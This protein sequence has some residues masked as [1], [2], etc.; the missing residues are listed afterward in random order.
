MRPCQC[1]TGC[2]MFITSRNPKAKYNPL[3]SSLPA[4]KARRDA[5]RRQRR[6]EGAPGL[7]DDPPDVIERKYRAGLIEAKA[8]PRHSDP[9]ARRFCP[10]VESAPGFTS[11]DVVDSRHRSSITKRRRVTRAVKKDKAA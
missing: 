3:C 10:L 9:W 4:S 6:K 1:G 5:R 11:E 8:K 7:D 2:G